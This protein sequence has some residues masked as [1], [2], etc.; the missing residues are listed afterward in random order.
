LKLICQIFYFAYKIQQNFT[1]QNG[2]KTLKIT[3]LFNGVA[4][5][6]SETQA[7]VPGEGQEFEI[8]SKKPVSLVS[9]GKK[10]ISP[11]LPPRKT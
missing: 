9:S 2:F 10:Q 3:L 4:R 8:F 6:F 11:L 7:W 5:T 1:V